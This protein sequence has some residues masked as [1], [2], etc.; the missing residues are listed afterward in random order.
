MKNPACSV[1][2]PLYNK[3]QELAATLASVLNQTFS[4]FELLV[5][6]DGST[7]RS[8]QIV[9]GFDDN[10]IFLFDQENAGVSAARNRGVAEAKS[11]LIVFIDADDLWHPD[12]LSTIVG[13]RDDYPQAKWFATGYEIVHPETGRTF[14]ALR[15]PAQNFQ[16]GILP[17]Y[18]VVAVCSDPPV[19]SSAT[20]VMREAITAIDGFPLGIGS[21]EDL[22]TW[23]RL[24]V[25]FPLA[26]EARNLAIF[27]V[28]G[29]H[30]RADPEN[31]VGHALE[32]LAKGFPQIPGLRAYL[33]LWYRMQAVM[34][35][36]YGEAG[37]AR[38]RAWLAVRYGPGQLRNLYTLL[39]ALMPAAWRQALD[40]RARSLLRNHAD[41]TK[42]AL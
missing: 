12:F 28:S 31:R 11:E 35:M 16:R 1:V 21:G 3:E 4:D 42:R 5:I 14:S 9:Q 8:V 2:M 37:W 36:R 13:L 30:R 6:N 25:R 18:F 39:L 32:L 22:L 7:D 41:K 38:Q 40:T 27:R 29:I 15:G 24:A 20:A 19:C 33:G 17:D 34:A 23:A 26:Y 10:R